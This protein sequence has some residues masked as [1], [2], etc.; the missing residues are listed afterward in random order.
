MEC[1][2]TVQSGDTELLAAWEIGS[3]TENLLVRIFE[4]S[5]Q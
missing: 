1:A 2:A 4:L 5:I 3:K